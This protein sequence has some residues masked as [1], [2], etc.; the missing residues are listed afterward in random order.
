[1]KDNQIISKNIEEALI[2]KN[3]NHDRL[4]Q[5]FLDLA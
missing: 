2:E 5:L 4:Y 3:K 1:M